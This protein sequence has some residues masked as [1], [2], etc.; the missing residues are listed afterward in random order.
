MAEEICPGCRLEL[1]ATGTGVD[2]GLLEASPEC[3]EV[4]AEVTGVVLAH[5][6]L[7]AR[8]HQT[9]VDAY[10]A[11]HAGPRT[12]DL[13]VFF[14]LNTLYLVLERGYTGIQGREAHGHLARTFADWPHVER[15][16]HRGETTVLDVAL[17]EEPDELAARV[18]GWGRSVWEAWSHAHDLVRQTTD[19]QLAGWSPSP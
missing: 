19:R 18:E 7:L 15:P 16:D 12:R 9:T 11:Q 5:P 14:A 17:A 6:R 3:V 2:G 4:Y 1:P 10:A 8:W 13:T